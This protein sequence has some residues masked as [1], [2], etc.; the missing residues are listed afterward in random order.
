MSRRAAPKANPA[1]RSTEGFAAFRRAVPKANP[2]VRSTEGFAAFRRAAPKA[3]PAVRSTQGDPVR[4]QQETA[5][6]CGAR[7]WS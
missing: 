7:L 6:A 5:A 1:V 2:A 4:C 3:N